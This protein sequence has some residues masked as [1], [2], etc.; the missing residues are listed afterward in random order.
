MHVR[1]PKCATVSSTARLASSTLVMSAGTTSTSG[2]P[3]SR[4]VLATARSAISVR[5]TSA[6][7]APFLAYSYTRCWT[8]DS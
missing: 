1:L 6:T 4:A 3:R 5:A 2:A 7:H 8:S